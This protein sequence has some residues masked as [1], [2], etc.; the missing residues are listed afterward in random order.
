MKS[1]IDY[2]IWHCHFKWKIKNKGACKPKVKYNSSSQRKWF[3]CASSGSTPRFTLSGP[4]GRAKALCYFFL[5]TKRMQKK[6]KVHVLTS[7]AQFL[8]CSLAQS[9]AF[10]HAAL[11]FA[12]SNTQGLHKA[13]SRSKWARCSV[14][15]TVNNDSCSIIANALSI[16]PEEYDGKEKWKHYWSV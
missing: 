15:L 12:C 7:Q 14:I 3:R 8:A 5:C 9:M 2:E 6:K 16:L 1:I 11:F 13:Q 4:I 10:A